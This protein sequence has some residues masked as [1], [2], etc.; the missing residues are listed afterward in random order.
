MARTSLSSIFV[1]FFSSPSFLFFSFIL[2]F[3]I[4]ASPFVVTPPWPPATQFDLFFSSSYSFVLFGFQVLFLCCISVFFSFLLPTLARPQCHC[5]CC[6][7]H[8]PLS[9]GRFVPVG[10][11]PMALKALSLSF[12]MVSFVSFLVA[13]PWNLHCCRC[14]AAIGPMVASRCWILHQWCHG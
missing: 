6:S 1:L 3:H 7:H 2:F 4:T 13:P 14:R 12:F 5:P 10:P 8:L 9:H 11:S